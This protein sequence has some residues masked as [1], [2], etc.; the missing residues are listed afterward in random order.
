MQKLRKLAQLWAQLPY[1]RFIK[2]FAIASL[3]LWLGFVFLFYAI[4]QNTSP[5]KEE[6][7]KLLAQSNP[8]IQEEK[9]KSIDEYYSSEAV[10]KRLTFIEDILKENGTGYFVGTKVSIADL[11]LVAVNG[12]FHE[13]LLDDYPNLKGLNE[14]VKESDNIKKYLANRTIP[15]LP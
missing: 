12:A 6:M 15:F 5:P 8:E 3:G 1:K 13:H 7:D 2:V 10:K 11:A 4:S 14:R 9:K